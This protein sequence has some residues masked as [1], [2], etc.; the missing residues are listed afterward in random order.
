MFCALFLA[1][2]ETRGASASAPRSHDVLSPSFVIDDAGLNGTDGISTRH[3]SWRRYDTE[4]R[5]VI[6]TPITV[7]THFFFWH[8]LIDSILRSRL[9]DLDRVYCPERTDSG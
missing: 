2:S 9:E 6:D 8:F 7:H 4:K 1:R 3:L 5:D